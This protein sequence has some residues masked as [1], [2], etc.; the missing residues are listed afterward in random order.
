MILTVPMVSLLEQAIC[1]RYYHPGRWT[2]S[3]HSDACKVPAIQRNL[4]QVRGWKAFFDTLSGMY[5]H[6]EE[7]SGV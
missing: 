4:A 5:P 3:L 7:N 6:Q 1:Q 2:G